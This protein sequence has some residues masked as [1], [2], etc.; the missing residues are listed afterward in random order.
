MIMMTKDSL[1]PSM[2]PTECWTRQDI[3]EIATIQS[4]EELIQIID[5]P[6]R[7]DEHLASTRTSGMLRCANDVRRHSELPIYILMLGGNSFAEE[8][9]DENVSERPMDVRRGFA[10]KV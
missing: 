9:R 1:C 2:A 10:Q 5:L 6:T 4:A 8:F 3:V 7:T